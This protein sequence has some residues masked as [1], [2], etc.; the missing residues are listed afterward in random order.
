MPDS[1]QMKTARTANATLEPM[2]PWKSKVVIGGVVGLL[3]MIAN[4]LD[5]LPALGF[6]RNLTGGDQE[7][8]TDLIV[9]LVG[10]GGSLTAIVSRWRQKAAPPIK[11]L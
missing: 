1:P 9:L 11:A 7:N 3:V 2:R 8:V 5:W 4:Y 6:L 10:G